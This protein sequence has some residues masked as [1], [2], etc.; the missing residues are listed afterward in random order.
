MRKST[1]ENVVVAGVAWV[2]ANAVPWLHGSAPLANC[3]YLA[4]LTAIFALM[5]FLF[6]QARDL[7]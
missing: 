7:F 2:G 5:F 3:L 1:V 4:L 6:L